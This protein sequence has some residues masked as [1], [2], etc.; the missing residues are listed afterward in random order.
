MVGGNG[1]DGG[2]RPPRLK[3]KSVAA[4]L[5]LAIALFCMCLT[6][7]VASAFADEPAGPAAD[8]PTSAEITEAIESEGPGLIPTQATNPS[9]AEK[10]PHQ[11]LGREEA[12][13][14]LRG[15]FEEQ[16]QN[17]AGILD[18][19]EVERFLAPDVAVISQSE[20]EG[21]EPEAA[22]GEEEGEV[23]GAVLLDSTVP[24][25]TESPSGEAEAVDLSLEHSEGEL[26]P[27][28]PLAEVNIPEQLGD[29]ITLPGPGVTID[30][31]GAPEEL[32]T[33]IVDESVGFLPNVA[34]DTDLVIAPTPTG[35]ETLTHLRSPEAPRVQTFDLQL[36]AGATVK[37]TEDGGAVVMEGQETL[38]SVSAPTAIDASGASVPVSL[39]VEGNSLILT[40]SPSSSTQ[41]P[42][43]V[44]PLYQTYEWAKSKWWQSGIFNNSHEPSA[45]NS[46]SKREEW[47]EE[48]GSPYTSGRFRLENQAWSEWAPVPMGTPGLWIDAYGPM[49][50]GERGSFIY[51]VPRYFTDQENYGGVKPTSYISNMTLSNVDWN[52]NSASLSPYLFL[53]IWDPVNSG[54]ISYYTHESLAGHGL[55]DMNWP[56]PFSNPGN[57]NGKVAY[58]SIHATQSSSLGSAELY[59]GN[60]S[61]QLADSIPPSIGP[62]TAQAKWV[63]QTA[64]PIAFTATDSGLG[65]H[66][67]VATDEAIPAHS[68]KTSQG[69][70]GNGGS[71][72]PRVWKN[73]DPSSPA[74]KYDPSQMPQGINYL[75]VVAEDP[76]G[77]KSPPAFAEVKVDHSAPTVSLSGT[78]TEQAVVGTNLT[79][80]KL[81]YSAS[82]GDS[83]APAAL[84]P[85]GTPGTGEG[86]MQRP[87]GIAVTDSGDSWVADRECKCVQKYDSAGKFVTQWNKAGVH[88]EAEVFLRPR[89]IAIGEGGSIWVTDEINKRVY[90]LGSAGNLLRT[91][92][93]SQGF[94]E[95]YAVAT[96]PGGDVW[97][98]DPAWQ[99]VFK[100]TPQSNVP[101]A[102]IGT[103]P[104]EVVNPLGLAADQSG[105][106]LVVDSGLS[107][108]NRFDSSGKYV[109][110]FGGAGSGPGQFST[111]TGIAVSAMGNF[112]VTDSANARVQVFRPNGTFVRQFGTS[113][114]ASNQFKEPRAIAMA[115][116]N[117]ALIADSG[118]QRIAKWSHA[119]LAPQSG[120]V[121]TEI[122]VDGKLVEPKYAP[123][124]ATQDCAI[125]NKEWTM[126]A[127]DLPVGLHKLELTATDGV[128][129]QTTKSQDFETKVVT[130]TLALSG[131]MTEQASLGTTRPRYKLRVDAS[132]EAGLE[133]EAAPPAY[134]STFGYFGTGNGQLNQPAGIARAADGSFWIADADNNRVQHFSAAGAYL[135][136]FGALGTGNGQLDK[137]VDVE[138]DA[139]GNIYVA[140]ADNDRIQKFSSTGTYLSQ[141]GTL[142]SGN[143][144]FKSPEGL[145]IGK[146]GSIFVADTRNNRIQ[147]FSSAGAFQKVIGSAGS[148][149]GQLFEPMG[150]DVGPGGGVFVADWDNNR[151]VV[152]S[153]EGVFQR[154]FGIEGYGDGQ[155]RGPVAID[156][157]SSGRVYVS[158][159]QNERI[160]QFD[161]AGNF[162][163]QFGTEGT[164]A[165][166]M[167]LTNP[168]GIVTG[169]EG[170]VWVTDSSNDRVQEWKVPDVLVTYTSTF[171]TAGTGNGQLNQPAGIVRAADGTF[172][173]ADAEND[174][175]Q[176]FSAAGAYLGK[177]GTFGTGN[178]QLDKPTDLEVDGAGNIYVADANNHRIQKFSST[179]AYVSKFGTSGT[180]NGQ[181]KWPEG[182]AIDKSGNIWVADTANNRLQKFSSSGTF[183]K[184]VGSAGSGQGQLYSPMGIDVGPGGGILVADWDN[185][186]VVVFNE[187][188]VFQRQFGIEGYDEG[189]FR[190]PVSI[191]VDAN[192]LVLVSD[193]KNERIEQFDQAGNFITQFGT[194]GTGAGQMELTNPMGIVTG[195]EGRIWITDSSNDRVQEWRQSKSVSEVFT[196]ILFDGKV[197]DS[198]QLKCAGSHCPVVREWQF[199]A[200]AQATGS[201]SLTAKVKDSLGLTR[202]K[203]IALSIQKDT[204]PP[205]LTAPN[206]FFTAPEGWVEQKTYTYAPYAFDP[207][208][209][210]VTSMVLKIDGAVVKNHGQ[211]CPD[212]GC[213]INPVTTI[214]VAPYAGGAHKA[215][216]IA[217]DG[218]GN[219]AK[220]TWTVNVDPDGNI[221]VEEAK[222]TL[223]AVEATSDSSLISP[224]VEDDE[225]YG[226]ST[227]L[228][229]TNDAG[230]FVAT[231]TAVPSVIE[232]DPAQGATLEVLPDGALSDP[233][234]NESSD[235]ETGQTEVV[236]DPEEEPSEQVCNTPA[237]PE[238]EQFALE[239]IEM[240]PTQTSGTASENILVEESSTLASNTMTHVDTLVRPLYE[241][242]LTFK[243]IRDASA[244]ESYSWDVS[245]ASGQELKLLDS[246]HA[247]VYYAGGHPAFSIT[248][249]PAH[250]AVGASV[251]TELS[252]SEGHIVTLKVSHHVPGL[253]YP[254]LA[255]SGWRGGFTTTVV[256]GPKDEQELKEERERIER[257][258]Q[259]ALE[260]EE[261]EEEEGEGLPVVLS[262]LQ[263]DRFTS[264]RVMSEGPPVAVASATGPDAGIKRFTFAK[265]YN[266]RECYY[267]GPD[268]ALPEVK[269]QQLINEAIVECK[270]HF[271]WRRLEAKLSVHGWYRGNTQLQGVWIA[272]NNNV[273]CDKWGMSV[274][275]MVHCRNNPGYWVQ[276][277]VHLTIQGDYRFWPGDGPSFLQP[278]GGAGTSACVT[279]RGTIEYGS[280]AHFDNEAEVRPARQGENCPWPWPPDPQ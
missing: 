132:A 193:E 190:G 270:S 267:D 147:K 246:E 72:C 96:A 125:T 69:C 260:A 117:V 253:V 42:V 233:C 24:L 81:K 170:K 280:G 159:E 216:L 108:V 18:Q 48:Y 90:Q 99:R 123:G 127:A 55:S 196:E 124:C 272:G 77:N 70:I 41:F 242:L 161:Q 133:G 198:G 211:L 140:D 44:D 207:N 241:G 7:G 197:V 168:M 15:V 144:Q 85:F 180:G 131:T 19:L 82:D 157:D 135:G 252:V 1:S 86:K 6:V 62:V 210:G 101:V 164:G 121:S 143:G 227:E 27:A 126:E 111:P 199:D 16:L 110:Q 115:P 189:E 98:A 204:T 215:E 230:N 94:K 134:I 10:L 138:I 17:P 173:V 89:G 23:A 194:E 249:E 53:G 50:A 185:D 176:H 195:S 54:W 149:Q 43:L 13:E 51:T 35:V 26:Q 59:V 67:L 57:S 217:T 269:R 142:G 65:A 40:T 277:G 104:N 52:A 97:V 152:F 201:H 107:R 261:E 45:S 84:T 248:A 236:L 120:A 2:S 258:E 268:V 103:K 245:L 130:P 34:T 186:R 218:A 163:T 148:G 209:Y 235:P 167:E 165:G 36:P 226:I 263:S 28:N 182:L 122:K 200:A 76:V 49:T 114:S 37:A 158:D 178:G 137:P 47:G 264:I 30:L 279:L 251:P 222:D 61:I 208:G 214:D 239:S 177:F 12:L 146:T 162:I 136:K 4:Q 160:E 274:P 169:P 5:R 95:P 38:V 8:L 228:G 175:V 58:A 153:E 3:T 75:Q 278:W 244:P 172:W 179:G 184:A 273:N 102:T 105:G 224:T 145:A 151:V 187:E 171:G 156:I 21:S 223:E 276:H 73:T 11:N 87:V 80:Y 265:K 128:G 14:L 183:L 93:Y 91:I 166:E 74:L 234:L 56:Y 259:E 271:G 79:Q 116:G 78:L 46:Y 71:A 275:A 266:F 206:S 106:V 32:A 181:F 257:E 88:P 221:S 141:F 60:A 31:A 220:K 231:G 255:G 155:F 212:G 100:F 213:G 191:E 83:A 202:S 237:V 9:A 25:R 256:D 192:G 29:G 22:G 203:T 240:A 238:G 92:N 20:L 243:T 139:A 188:G 63:H 232:H 112:L 150:I 119:D 250:D 205:Q 68:W 154:Q 225:Y 247:V 66:S 113:G 118:N 39:A 174:R 109:G 262:V 229:L 33:S 64:Q 219:A 254:V 129:L